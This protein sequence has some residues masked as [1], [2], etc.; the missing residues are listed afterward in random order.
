MAETKPETT[1]Q[2]VS[3]PESTP[4]EKRYILATGL[5]DYARWKT[6]FKDKKGENEPP[7]RRGCIWAWSNIFNSIPKL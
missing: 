1:A 3:E 4:A 2:K 5:E 7:F 6:M